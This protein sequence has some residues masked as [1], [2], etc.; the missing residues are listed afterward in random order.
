MSPSPRWDPCRLH[1]WSGC[2]INTSDSQRT[3]T[4][5]VTVLPLTMSGADHPAKI[6]QQ[7]IRRMLM[8]QTVS[9]ILLPL[10]HIALCILRPVKPHTHTHTHTH[11]YRQTLSQVICAC[12]ISCFLCPC[13]CFASPAGMHACLCGCACM[14]ACICMQASINGNMRMYRCMHEA[15]PQPFLESKLD[16]LDSPKKCKS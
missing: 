7:A 12:K 4:L 3:E 1:A 5:C 11:H 14:Q 15:L 9:L 2:P 13:I 6:C 10:V 8:I 16:D